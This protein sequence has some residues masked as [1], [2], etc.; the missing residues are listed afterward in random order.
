MK[1]FVAVVRVIAL[2]VAEMDVVPS[3]SKAPDCVTSPPLVRFKFP[4]ASDAASAVPEAS[5]MVTFVPAKSSEPKFAVDAS[6][7]V[8][9]LPLASKV[10]RLVT[11][12]ASL[13]V[14]ASAFTVSVSVAVIAPRSIALSSV[15]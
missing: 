14:I 6:P 11:V 4:V 9:A 12:I 7:S 13:S 3:T 8:I 1:S 10:A 5:V 2:P 15:I